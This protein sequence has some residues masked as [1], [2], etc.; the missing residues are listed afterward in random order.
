[1]ERSRL[2]SK[3]GPH[4]LGAVVSRV[5]ADRAMATAVRTTITLVEMAECPPLVEL[6][7]F[8]LARRTQACFSSVTETG[9]GLGKMSEAMIGKMYKLVTALMDMKDAGKR[10]MSTCRGCCLMQRLVCMSSRFSV[11]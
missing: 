3:S 5:H 11:Y 2:A 1:M 7:V 10:L 9:R 6:D 4:R 8:P